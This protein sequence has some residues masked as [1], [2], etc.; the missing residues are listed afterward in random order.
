MPSPEKKEDEPAKKSGGTEWKIGDPDPGS[1]WSSDEEDRKVTKLKSIKI[2][3]KKKQEATKEQLDSAMSGL[4][5]LLGEIPGQRKSFRGVARGVAAAIAVANPFGTADAPAATFNPFAAPA[6]TTGAGGASKGA[7]PNPFGEADASFNPFAA[8]PTDVAVAAPAA[9]SNNPFGTPASPP[10]QDAS[11]NPFA[12]SP[13][14]A[15]A[16]NPFA[17]EPAADATFNPFGAPST[18]GI[19]D[20]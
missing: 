5:D 11:F 17:A 7:A 3:K 12:S 20:E 2:G 1:D 15:A 4:G 18:G 9:D 19:E 14:V 8:P 13:P 10:A 6:D 16:N